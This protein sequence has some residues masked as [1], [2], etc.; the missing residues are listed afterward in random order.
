MNASVFSRFATIAT[1]VATRR[2]DSAWASR[3][4]LSVPLAA[5][6]AVGAVGCTDPTAGTAAGQPPTSPSPAVTASATPSATA[7]APATATATAAATA[8]GQESTATATPTAARAAGSG[9]VAAG[10]E[11]TADKSVTVRFDGLA[12]GNRLP[13]GGGQV[14]FSVTWTNATGHRLAAV[15]PVVAAQP[16]AGA[17]CRIVEGTLSGTMQ[18]KDGNVWT[19]VPITQGTGMDYATTGDKAAFA[20]APGASRTV[21][22]RMQLSKDNGPAPLTVEADAYVAK[23]TRFPL[24]GKALRNLAVVD[25]HRPTASMPTMTPHP[26]SVTVGG[27]AVEVKVSPGNF[28]KAPFG[29]LAPLLTLGVTP[30]NDYV[31]EGL[32]AADVTAE[33]FT[34]G[35]WVKLPTSE[36]CG[37]V[38]VD[39][40]SLAQPLENGPNGRVLNHLFRFSVNSGLAADVTSLD[41]SAGALADGHYAEPVTVK[42]AVRR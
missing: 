24:L 30:A 7:T 3:L 4:A 20:L 6:L 18:R 13:A 28:T 36:D 10:T 5:V 31:N 37:R 17:R 42:V 14:A 9:T 19:D 2:Q 16:F 25:E 40:G 12:E 41:V 33:V 35:S 8:A 22:Y 23:D 26:T 1:T 39:T 34:G 29:S 38:T 21:Q 32:G 11:P 27:P 15:A